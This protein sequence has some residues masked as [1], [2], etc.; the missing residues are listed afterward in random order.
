M[1]AYT[2]VMEFLPD[3][4]SRVSGA[5]M[6]F[7]GLLFFLSPLFLQYVS[8]NLNWM[9]LASFLLNFIAVA[10]F[11]SCRIPE[12]LKFLLTKGKYQEFWVEYGKVERLSGSHGEETKR[13][14]E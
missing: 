7:D 8:N 6:C 13:K 9:F 12:S 2:H 11:I 1:V 3:R 10:V 4:E 5:F 14:V